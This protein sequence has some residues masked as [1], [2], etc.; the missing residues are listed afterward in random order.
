MCNPFYISACHSK[1][2]CPNRRMMQVMRTQVDIA[3]FASR[4]HQKLQKQHHSTTSPPHPLYV[5]TY[6]FKKLQP[7]YRQAL[8]WILLLHG[9]LGHS[10]DFSSDLWRCEFLDFMHHQINGNSNVCVHATCVLMWALDIWMGVPKVLN[11]HWKHIACVQGDF[12]GVLVT[13]ITITVS[14]HITSLCF[15]SSRTSRLA[16]KKVRASTCLSGH[17]GILMYFVFSV[18]SI[19]FIVIAVLYHLYQ[20]IKPSKGSGSCIISFTW[21][22]HKCKGKGYLGLI[23]PLTVPHII[24][25]GSSPGGPDQFPEWTSHL[26]VFQSF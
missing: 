20:T 24:P 18:H 11:K 7:A 1:T 2:R 14:L 22:W 13:S 15:E 25:F 12:Q 19:P 21:L 16:R 3:S 26:Q 6:T 5:L 8:V 23:D 17:E 9:F 10:A 4:A